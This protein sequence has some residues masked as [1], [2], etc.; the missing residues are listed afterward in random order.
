[1]FKSTWIMACR[2]RK[3]A[4]LGIGVG[5]LALS[6]PVS[7]EPPALP[8]ILEQRIPDAGTIHRTRPEEAAP[9]PPAGEPLD[10]R[11]PS[12]PKPAKSDL[13]F[14][15]KGWKFKGATLVAEADLQARLQGLVGRD[16]DMKGL[17]EAVRQVDLLYHERGFLV[18][19]WLP[20][21][22]IKGGFVEIR[23]VE[24]KLGKVGMEGPESVL[25]PERAAGTILAAQPPGEIL[26]MKDL[27]RGVLL[28]NDLPGIAV[29]P[30]LKPGGQ[31]G[32]SDLALKLEARPQI[33]G[34]L[35]YANAGVRAVG[36]HQF[37]GSVY[38]NNALGIGDQANFRM[39]GGSGNVYGR[40]SYSVPVGYSGLRVGVAG[41]GMYYALGNEYKPLNASGDAWIGGIYASY[42]L[43]RSSMLNVYTQAGFDTRR[44][45]NVAQGHAISDKTINVGYVGFQ[46]DAHDELLGG[47]FNN[48][49]FFA[50]AGSLDIKDIDT[51]YQ[52]DQAT[53]R[54]AGSYQKFSFNASRL[55][56][57]PGEFSFWA[58][59]IGQLATKNL[60][61]SEKFS[62]GGPYGVRAYP[63]NEGLGD[64]G[65]LM[66]FE[67]R[68]E[69]YPNVQLVGF[70]DHGGTTL[71]NTPW[72]GSAGTGPNHY[73][74]SGGGFGINWIS[75]G[76]FAVKLS[77]AQRIG[78]NPQRNLFNNT[79]N[80][81]SHDTPHFWAQLSKYF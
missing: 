18:R 8:A 77:I 6:P 56:K 10:I 75:P 21:Q 32:E 36:E 48:F 5:L 78:N 73:T 79:D 40:L 57:L 81:G 1:M 25:S 44:Y 30:T 3:A 64:E 11:H 34:S 72:L 49:G 65:Y 27:E 58:N 59:F 46:G 54:A 14:P 52:L 42:P 20:E 62:L 71:H 70:F 45:H 37:A 19:A 22:D 15:L 66:N 67:L 33:T 39:Q 61:S 55:Q 12:E 35:D 9:I 53:S 31:P 38:V 60:D 4:Y 2:P 63:I 47:G 16:I 13:K 80:D 26:R 76:D 28:L 74:L 51:Y 23:L 69:V 50:S 29:T 43:V 41:S 68:Y 17:W 7:A 24:G